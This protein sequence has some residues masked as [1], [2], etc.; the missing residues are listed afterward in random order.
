MA[1]AVRATY[2]AGC[3]MIVADGMVVGLCSYKGPPDLNGVVEIGYGVAP[4]CRQ[5]GYATRAVAH[6]LTVAAR[7]SSIRSMVAETTTENLASQRVLERNGFVRGS[8]RIDPEDGE[9]VL[10][11]R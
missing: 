5:R 8:K 1:V 6:L 4:S 2:G 9:V 7:D 11:R 10:W 3:W